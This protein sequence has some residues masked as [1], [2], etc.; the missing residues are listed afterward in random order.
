M[1]SN[2]IWAEQCQMPDYDLDPHLLFEELEEEFPGIAL[3]DSYPSLEEVEQQAR[4]YS[5]SIFHSWNI[6]Y[7]I[8]CRREEVIRRRWNKK[9]KEQRQKILLSASPDIPSGHRPDH[10]IMM[11]LLEKGY[12]QCCNKIKPRFSN[13]VK[14]RNE[15]AFKCPQINLEDLTKGK[16]LLL[17]LNCRGR[18]LPHIFAHTD[19]RTCAMGRFSSNIPTAYLHGYTMYLAGQT[20][21][22]S[23]GKVVHWED[24]DVNFGTV[25]QTLQFQP[26]HG[27]LVLEQ[28]KK[29]LEF[30]VECCFQILKDV[31][32]DELLD[33]EIAAQP[34]PHPLITNEG[35]S[36]VQLSTIVAEEPYRLPTTIDT[37]RLLA[38]IEARRTAAED[39]IWEMKEDPG[40]FASVLSDYHEHRAEVL[41]DIEGK[42]H[43][44]L[45]DAHSWDR[46]LST[47]VAS[48]YEDLLYWN[49]LHRHV[50]MLDSLLRRSREILDPQQRLNEKLEKQLTLVYSTLRRLC[51]IMTQRF[52]V[53]F[54]CSHPMRARFAR[55]PHDSGTAF[56][57]EIL[58]KGE[59]EPL[60][61][62]VRHLSRHDAQS[63]GALHGTVDEMQ[64]YL[65]HD[66][67]QKNVFSSFVAKIFSDLALITQIAYQIDNFYPWAPLF[68]HK[69]AENFKEPKHP[70]ANV[71]GIVHVLRQ[72]KPFNV[73]TL[74]SPRSKKFYYPV[75]KAYSA[76]QV[77]AMQKAE[78]NLDEVWAQLEA[79]FAANYTYALFDL[80]KAHYTSD[81]REIRRT[82][83]YIPLEEDPV[84]AKCAG[85]PLDA[86][87]PL[88]STSPFHQDSLK[89]NPVIKKTKIKTRGTPNSPNGPCDR[90]YSEEILKGA[91]LGR[92]NDNNV[93]DMSLVLS[94]RASK[95]LTTL[96]HIDATSDQRG[97]IP[98]KDFLHAMTSL[99][100]NV[101]KLYG[102]VWQFTPTTG[103]VKRGVHVHEPHPSGK[104]PFHMARS[105]GRRLS[106]TYGWI[107]DMFDLA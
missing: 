103:S 68:I 60:L 63:M 76:T 56:D 28:Q 24:E 23:Y 52:I 73:N 54:S 96:F 4:A 31:P 104:I 69:R 78:G 66:P 46:I 7:H 89:Y 20:T 29:I 97:E 94:K 107:D 53:A 5:K 84:K 83:G 62:L 3:P 91:G 44:N 39:H 74:V 79:Y 87:I 16:T 27:L 21:E 50:Y 47:A 81:Q 43:P 55:C 105:I 77:E 82:P 37:P 92:L 59:F 19:L 51:R 80:F 85:A 38:L 67:A 22:E 41:R 40:Y 30:L 6:L 88:I 33:L 75:E 26:G 65:D 1:D 35:T 9:C 106:R 90:K 25:G 17:F 13:V 34:E 14:A 8:L 2:S 45:N 36:Y 32:R 42:C 101:E 71:E 49:R 95:V 93:V 11:R 15:A 10:Q 64:Y 58:I 18:N 99:H 102:S 57:A 61:V 70:A 48:A 12:C 86:N 72:R 100:F 98:W